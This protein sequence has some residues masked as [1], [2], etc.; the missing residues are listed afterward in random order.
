VSLCQI[1]T[2]GIRRRLKTE[3]W[4]EWKHLSYETSFV[5][6]SHVPLICVHIPDDVKFE[7]DRRSQMHEIGRGRSEISVT[8]T[9]C[10][11]LHAKNVRASPSQRWV[12]RS[13]CNGEIDNQE[14]PGIILS[15]CTA[16][17]RLLRCLLCN[18]CQFHWLRHERFQ[19]LIANETQLITAHTQ[20]RQALSCG[21]RQTAG[22]RVHGVSSFMSVLKPRARAAAGSWCHQKRGH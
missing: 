6:V 17:R 14:R 5:S 8:K 19:S 20:W 18:G 7:E 3:L 4:V 21:R 9:V 15:P 16:G 1:P 10:R 13:P 22:P 11:Q 2:N 12:G